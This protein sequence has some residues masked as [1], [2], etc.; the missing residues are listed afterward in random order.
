[1]QVVE[2]NSLYISDCYAL[3]E[4]AGVIGRKK[5]QNELI[6]RA[7]QFSYKMQKIWDPDFGAFLNYRTDVDT[8]SS[9]ISP[10]MFYPLLAD[11]GYKDQ[12]DRIVEFFYDTN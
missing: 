6:E 8:L 5:E 4:M 11:L 2:L 10:T 3:A 1:L 9:R 7:K 12:T